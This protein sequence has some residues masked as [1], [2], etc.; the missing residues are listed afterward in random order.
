MN[1]SNH[2]LAPFLQPC[3][4]LISIIHTYFAI[5]LRDK[6]PPHVANPSENVIKELRC[7]NLRGRTSTTLL[8]R[9]CTVRLPLEITKIQGAVYHALKK[10]PVTG[11]SGFV[12]G[13]QLPWV[14][15][16]ALVLGARKLLTV[17]YQNIT[18]YGT[19]KLT[20]I[21]PIDFAKQWEKYQSSFD[22][23]M[24]FS[25]IE[26]SGPWKIWRSY[27]SNGDLRE[28]W[29]T[30]CLLKPGG[31]LFHDLAVVIALCFKFR[32]SRH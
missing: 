20:Y 9:H 22:F 32:E 13:S 18:I 29:K 28:M 2:F 24:S 11:K 4:R 26:H 15:V 7:D 16:Y 14:E 17:D 23:A 5:L 19:D 1:F 31:G 3:Y 25:S 6:A 21:H 27:R 12:V 10:Y 8:S 30:L